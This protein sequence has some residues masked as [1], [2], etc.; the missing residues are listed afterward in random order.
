M[1]RNFIG[2]I[3]TVAFAAVFCFQAQA[4]SNVLI[5]LLD[6]FS[7][8]H[9]QTETPYIDAFLANGI[10]FEAAA[11]PATICAPARAAFL[12]G[13]TAVQTN[14]YNNPDDDEWENLDDVLTLPEVFAHYG[15]TDA[16]FGRVFHSYS[17]TQARFTTAYSANSN[18]TYG[19]NQS[20]YPTPDTNFDWSQTPTLAEMGDTD[21]VADFEDWLG[22]LDEEE[23]WFAMVGLD[24]TH[25][26]YHCPAGYYTETLANTNLPTT[27]ANDQADVPTSAQHSNS[28]RDPQM[29]T[30]GST[31][32]R[33]LTYAYLNCVSYVDA[34]TGDVLDAL[35]NSDFADNTIVVIVADH[36]V[37][38]GEKQT[39]GK[40]TSWQPTSEIVFGWQIPG[41]DAQA[42]DT[43]V[44]AGAMMATL[45]DLNGIPDPYGIA[46]GCRRS[47]YRSLVPLIDGESW[48]GAGVTFGGNDEEIALTAAQYKYIFTGEDLADVQV[49]D[50]NN[51]PNEFVNIADTH[52]TS[53]ITQRR[54]AAL[55]ILAGNNDPL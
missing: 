29:A 55:T 52:D 33:S 45:L 18:P 11:A 12:A 7:M 36:G 17:D 16:S 50:L 46:C 34:M 30:Y 49:Y 19:T 3:L 39:Y 10:E 23:L 32:Q 40:L 8:R 26:P 41:E 53:K 5:V 13:M 42:I 51:D 48:N 1:I 31:A 43:P 25:Q 28:N 54:N 9:D 37:H 47:D 24:A 38:I 14:I 44:N 2:L 15:Y 4:Q 6:D 21:T 35:D 27:T 22:E 20:G